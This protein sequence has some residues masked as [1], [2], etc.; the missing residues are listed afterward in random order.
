MQL[1]LRINF[2]KP[3]VIFKPNISPKFL[4]SFYFDTPKLWKNYQ[5][6]LSKLEENKKV[7]TSGRVI[8]ENKYENTKILT[9]DNS[10]QV[11][12]NSCPPKLNRS[13]DVTGF[14]EKYQ[15]KTQIKAIS[16]RDLS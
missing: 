12:C 4:L 13:I 10:I 9:L 6:E 2:L 7:Q 15:N 16:I 1:A 3:F 11:I 5:S 8:K 14:V